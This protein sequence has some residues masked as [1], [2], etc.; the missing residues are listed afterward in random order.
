MSKSFEINMNKSFDYFE[1][2]T[3]DNI[4][5]NL[6]Y[7]KVRRIQKRI[8]KA[9]LLGDT[10]RIWF[11]QKLILRN[12]H[13]KLIAVQ[14]VTTLNKGKGTAGIDGLT[15]TSPE[16][17]LKLAKNL[18]LNGKA[19]LVRR[20]WIPKPGK[21]EKRPLGIPTI[22]DRA[23]QALCK[24]ALEPEWE[25]KFEPN[26]YGFRPGRSSHDAI[27]AIFQNLHY[28]VDKYIYDADIRKCFDTIDH[29]AL[30]LKLNTFPL[31]EKQISAWLKAGIF[32]Q[33]A[34]TPKTSIPSM[35]T[36]QGG[37]ISPLLANIALHGL[38]EHLLNYVSN[39]KFPK[40]HAQ[41][42]RGTKVKKAALGIVRYADDFVIIHR[43]KEILDL[44]IQ[45]T[46]VWLQE[47]G[48]TISEEKSN[49][50][51]ASQTFKFLGFQVAY[52]KVQDKFRVRIT[53]SKENVMR[54][55]AK[56]KG[57]IQNNKAAS[58]Y[59]LIGKLRP[60]ILGWANYFQFCECKETFS[61]VDNLLYQQIRAWVFR[62]AVRQGRITVKEKYFP[63]EKIYKFQNRTYKANWILNG[64]KTLKNNKP[65]IIYLPKISWIKSKKYVKVKGNESVYNGNE[66]YWAL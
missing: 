24:L 11:L 58:A 61:K 51:L 35:G 25:A 10:K 13:A 46:K 5:W 14:T 26:S 43:N 66:I 18:Q 6:S 64:T 22:Q 31:M 49:V 54:I 65:M 48:L 23:K 28:N 4:V 21:T 8:F 9:S 59:E 36:P 44:I 3:W 17:K 45:E 60:V 41:A 12:P 47:M 29:K 2:L 55:I 37:V 27:E 52:V 39:R 30:L 62:R 1:G 63:S 20:V 53:P 33:Y 57:I 19:N 16:T 38:E 40:P 32:D 15:V 50:R 56:T 34:N 42:A 7:E